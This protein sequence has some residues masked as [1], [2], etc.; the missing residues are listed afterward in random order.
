MSPQSR[1]G[2]Q[3]GFSLIEILA[4]FT[5]LALVLLAAYAGASTSLLLEH[6]AEFSRKATLL[7]RSKLEQLGLSDPIK[8]G[9]SAGAEEGGLAWTLVVTPD[10]TPNG[11][12][13]LAGFWA[14]VTISQAGP[15]KRAETLAFTTLKL[16]PESP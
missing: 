9:S 2:Q 11:S 8:L 6:R 1:S 12:A 7:A 4:A 14:T 5:I 13:G 16:G 3:D 10:R 15:R